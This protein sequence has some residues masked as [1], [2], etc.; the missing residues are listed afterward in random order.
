MCYTEQPIFTSNLYLLYRCP[1]TLNMRRLLQL[2]NLYHTSFACIP[3]ALSCNMSH[4]GRRQL[5]LND[6]A[7]AARK[8]TAGPNKKAKQ[9]P[10]PPAAA[11]GRKTSAMR[12]QVWPLI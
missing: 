8:R 10:E 7:L 6:E 9:E 1:L 11:A 3:D 5:A 2:L 4:C 12:R